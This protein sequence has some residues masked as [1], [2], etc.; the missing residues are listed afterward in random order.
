M[1][2]HPDYETLASVLQ[3]AYD[4][5]AVGKGAERHARS[6]P[7]HEQHMQTI[8]TLL[9]SDK[10]MAYQAVKKLTEGLDFTDP[11]R[12]ERELLGV[13][14]YVAGLVVWHRE[15]ATKQHEQEPRA[16]AAKG[17]LTVH[18]G[19]Q[20]EY[21]NQPASCP[22]C[23][24]PGGDLHYVLCPRLQVPE[25][26]AKAVEEAFA[27]EQFDES[28]ADII[29]QNSNDGEHYAVPEGVDINDWRTWQVGD[30]L[31]CIL[32]IDEGDDTCDKIAVG[33]IVTLADVEPPEYG[34]SL[35]VRVSGT[36]YRGW[37]DHDD[38]SEPEGAPLRQLFRFHHRPAKTD[39]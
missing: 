8:S 18:F 19:E 17:K 11:D 25:E 13:I 26:H 38:Y 24:A 1:M 14:V 31:E 37:P 35:P 23:G 5:A 16:A 3:A 9:N 20:P 22:D 6:N 28:R 10:G 30:K 15:R 32:T 39:E 2:D 4:Q 21:P 36:E 7:F 12:R 29:G 27:A 34:G 33:E